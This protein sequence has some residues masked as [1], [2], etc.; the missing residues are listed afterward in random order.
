VQFA[1]W[2]GARVIGTAGPANHGYL[3]SLGA[4]PVAYGD[5]LVAGVWD[6]VPEGASVIIDLVGATHWRRRSTWATTS[7][8]APLNG[9]GANA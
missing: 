5:G 3:R 4:E 2:A 7:S 9:V 1:S 6:L 8:G